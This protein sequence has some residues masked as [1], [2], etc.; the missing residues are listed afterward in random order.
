M[1]LSYYKCLLRRLPTSHANYINCVEEL[2]RIEAG[3]TGEERV[4]RELLD[5]P[6]HYFWLSNYQCYSPQ[7]TP[8]QIDFI[9]ICP[10]FAVVLEVKNIS[11][12]VSYQT[13]GKEF[14]RTRPDGQTDTFRNPFDQ[15][16][17]HQQM[18]EQLFTR[19]KIELPVTHAVIMTNSNTRICTSF[20]NLPIF[21]VTY[22]R[23]YLTNLRKH[24]PKQQID[25]DPL[26]RKLEDYACILPPRQK[27]S[28][29]DILPGI[30]CSSCLDE[31]TYLKGVSTCKSCGKRSRTAILETLRGYYFLNDRTITNRDLCKFAKLGSR[32][33]ATK[34]LSKFASEKIG[35]GRNIHY[36]LPHSLTELPL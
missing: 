36:K 9:I 29:K 4:S 13:V 2:Q 15:A 3:M 11:G 17:R 34:I 27:V 6:S 26:K 32:H 19:W 31:M 18:L 22:L 24:F 7:H 5:L 21:H 30:I 20:G 23:R 35:N 12:T 14:I 16:F 1:Q 28:P 8:H 25:L 10:H 33:Q